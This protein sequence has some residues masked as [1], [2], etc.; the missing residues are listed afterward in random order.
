M[1]ANDSIFYIYYIMINLKIGGG[2]DSK[3]LD[4]SLKL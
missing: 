1:S 4:V 2:A 3:V